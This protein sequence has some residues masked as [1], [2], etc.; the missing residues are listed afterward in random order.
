VVVAPA[1]S[2][3]APSALVNKLPFWNEWAGTLATGS[4]PLFINLAIIAFGVGIAVSKKRPAGLFP[5]TAFLV[6]GF[7]NALVRSSGWRFIQPA[8]WIILVYYSI[9]LAYLPYRIKSFFAETIQ[10]QKNEPRLLSWKT[11]FPEALI[12]FGLLLLAA[13]VPIAERVNQ[14]SGYDDF[15]ERAQADLLRQ[16]LISPAEIDAFLQQKNTVL[17]SGMALY[18]RYIRPG[19]RIYLADAPRGYKYLHLWLMNEEDHQI[20]LPLQTSPTG[21]P[22]TAMI[23]VLGCREDRYISAYAIM[24]H[25]PSRQILI[26]DPQATLKCPLAAPR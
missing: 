24:I 16:N 9:A 1:Y 26:R 22:H 12:L 4:L 8:D 23:S 17:L 2:T 3:D 7:G 6:Y 15:A 25:Q 21:I 20:V 18:P 14:R 19:V 11:S 13:S 5:L 10:V